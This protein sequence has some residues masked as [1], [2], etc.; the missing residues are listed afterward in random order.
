M[1]TLNRRLKLHEV[2]VGILGSRNVYFQPPADYKMKYPC[3]VYERSQI[4]TDFA[5]NLP[6]NFR[7]RY[8]VTVIDKDP[9]SDLPRKIAAL[10]MCAHDRHYTA[11]NLHHDVFNL[12]F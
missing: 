2:L 1:F 10:P 3:I 8:Q 6:Y 7:D 9:D 4:E 5:D 12:Y 11:N